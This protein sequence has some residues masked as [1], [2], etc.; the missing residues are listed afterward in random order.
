VSLPLCDDA[1]M[2]H[3]LWPL[4]DLRLRTARLALRPPT[5]EDLVSLCAVAAAGIH[6]PGEMPFAFPWTRKPSPRFEREFAQYHWQTRA[7]WQPNSWNL[8]FMVTLDGRPIG[9]QGLF[10][11]EF[12]VHRLV[13]TGSWLGQA[14]QR[15]GFGT[16]MRQAVLS[17][18]FDG[19]GAEVAETEA[20]LENIAS[21]TVSRRVGYVENGIGRLAP[22]GVARDVQRFR[23]T[24]EDWRSSARPVVEIDG[25]DACREMFA[26]QPD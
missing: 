14:Y 12:P 7:G 15:R 2:T 5:D 3:P 4:F 23:L 26:S 6:D 22:D 11:R 8:E 13:H 25:L 17:F 24:A 10:A 9:A 20:F 19:L 16:E 18:A 1:A 21:A